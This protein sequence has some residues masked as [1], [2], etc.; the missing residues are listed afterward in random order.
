MHL[1]LPYSVI[2]IGDQVVHILQQPHQRLHPQHRHLYR[3]GGV[4]VLH[5]PD[6]RPRRITI[7][8]SLTSI[9]Y[10]AFQGC[11]S[12]TNV[13]IPNS[14]TSIGGSAFGWCTSLTSIT[15]PNSVTSIGDWAFHSCTGL[16]AVYFK[17]NAPT[18]TYAFGGATNATIYYVAGTTG[19]APTFGGRPTT[20][21]YFPNPVMY[22]YGPSF[23]VQPRWL[24]FHHL[25]GRGCARRGRSYHQPLLL[26]TLATNTITMG[27]DPLTDGW[28]SFRDS[29]WTNSPPFIPPPLT[30]RKPMKTKSSLSRTPSPRTTVRHLRTVCAIGI[31]PLLLLAGPPCCGASPR[32]E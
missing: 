24:R 6:Q 31:L 11:T 26:D 10:E 23:P 15:I 9:G 16:S 17:G 27:I 3:G 2:S 22:T 13:T 18:A 20:L 19:W 25:L 14:V 30:M 5:R 1:S 12:L 7:P 8:S 32:A 4:P 21:S 29:D 28:S